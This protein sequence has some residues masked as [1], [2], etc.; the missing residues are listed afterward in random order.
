MYP[1]PPVWVEVDTDKLR[2]N[3]SKVKA[4]VATPIAAVVKNNAYG[5]GLIRTS[6][7]FAKWGANMLA[8]N[9]LEEARALR[10]S[11]INKPIL[12]L[13]PGLPFQAEQVALLGLTQTLCTLPMA[14][15]LIQAGDKYNRRI[16]VH[17]KIDV[18]MG[19]IGLRPDEAIEFVRQT[20]LLDPKGIL[21]WDGIY[22]H[23]PCASNLSKTRKQLSLFLGTVETLRNRDSVFTYVHA[24]NS[25]AA[26]VLPESRLELARIGNALYGQCT[27]SST[28]NTWCLKAY[29]ST[30]KHLYRGDTLGYA[31][32]YKATDTVAIGTI[33]IGYGDGLLLEP[34]GSPLQETLKGLNT[35]LASIARKILRRDHPMIHYRGKPTRFLGRTSMGMATIQVPMDTTA[36][37]QD[38]VEIYQRFT[39]IPPHIPRVFMGNG[40]PLCAEISY[41]TYPIVL[42]E[43]H[44][45]LV[46][47]HILPRL[48]I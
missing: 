18:G 25:T 35:W 34:Q 48:R 30:V 2:S 4:T 5:H 19:R 47:S 26:M 46:D 15:A 7:F 37:M 39:S 24:A 1:L 27:A 17:L 23:F 8:V 22:T 13:C 42:K 6:Q 10:K 41:R 21:V 36:T 43:G 44:C 20:R 11:G 29:V 9:S 12:V 40:R 16:K 14:K 28:E 3:F 31:S 32:T 45:Y 38:P 33:P